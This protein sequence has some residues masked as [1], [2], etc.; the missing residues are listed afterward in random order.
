MIRTR[1]AP[2]PTGRLHLGHAY[3]AKVARDLARSD[4]G[5]F[6][7][8][9][10]DID[11][12]RVR[13]EFYQGI[14]EDL[15]WLGLEWDGVPLR[16]TARLAAYDAALKTLE[17]RGVLYPCFCTR[18]EIDSEIA[19]M[20]GAPHGP[21]GPLYPGT[22]KRLPLS[23]RAAKLAGG[24]PFSWRLDAESAAA[25]TGPL[26]FLDLLHGIQEVDPGL[27]GDVILARKDIGTSYHLAVVVDDAYQQIT[28][29]TRGE[30]LLASTHVHRLLQ[31]LLGFPEPAYL[32]HRVLT[33]ETGKRLAKRHDS[34]SIRVLREGGVSVEDVMARLAD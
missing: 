25:A 5:E 17:Q 15:R 13:E 16:Q 2:S 31:T 26:S 23:E 22:C 32:H 3:A 10:E 18:R 14:E 6:L 30:D 27:L 8:R 33:D 21:E 19:R 4:S 12:T 11:T 20:A 28:H 1:F 7:L 24:L 9:F 34:L 29:V